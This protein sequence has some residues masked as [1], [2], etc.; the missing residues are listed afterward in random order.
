MR[1]QIVKKMKQISIT[2][3]WVI[4]LA[5]IPGVAT[6]PCTRNLSLHCM[7]GGISFC[8]CIVTC[9]TKKPT[10]LGRMNKIAKTKKWKKREEK[11]KK[12]T[13]NITCG[14]GGDS[15]SVRPNTVLFGACCFYLL[16]CNTSK[17][18]TKKQRITNFS[19]IPSKH[20]IIPCPSPDWCSYLWLFFFSLDY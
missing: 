4:S 15:A 2:I 7:S 6:T 19:C 5:A 14:S 10:I 9:I 17:I 3:S 1:T 8:A 16:I 12:H 18:K 20:I 11:Q 13:D